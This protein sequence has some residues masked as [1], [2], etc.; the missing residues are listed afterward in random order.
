MLVL[1]MHTQ[2]T[3]VYT[4]TMH[5]PCNLPW[6]CSITYMACRC[7]HNRQWHLSSTHWSLH[8]IHCSFLYPLPLPLPSPPAFQCLSLQTEHLQSPQEVTLE[9]DRQPSS[10]V[11]VIYSNNKETRG[12]VNHTCIARQ[13]GNEH[14]HGSVHMHTCMCTHSHYPTLHA[15]QQLMHTL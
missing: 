15:K 7:T 6:H 13:R 14:M 9:W 8:Q 10:V 1:G 12:S 2:H 4:T 5:E 11:H 3:L